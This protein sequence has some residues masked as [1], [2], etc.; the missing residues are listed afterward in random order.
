MPNWGVA[1]VNFGLKDAK[2]APWLGDGT[3]GINYDV[4]S[5]QLMGITAQMVNGELL[6]DD[7][8]TD[9]HAKII[10]GRCRGRWGGLSL[11]VILAI[12]N[13]V[14][15]STGSTPNRVRRMKLA[16]ESMKYFGM[17]GKSASTNA[18][19]DIHAWI[20]KM[21]IVSDITLIE[22]QN[23]QYTIPEFE[24][25]ML[26]DDLYIA[27]A[28]TNELQ[29]LTITGTPTGGTFLLTFMGAT[30][31]TI[32]YNAAAAAVQTALV[33]LATIGTGNVVCGGGPLPGT[34]VTITFQG[35]LASQPL[36]LITANGAGLTGG[37][38][39]TASVARTTQGVEAKATV[40]ELIEHETAV[41]VTIPP[42]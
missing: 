5:A 40:T 2:V 26:P 10:A 30:T 38:S 16:A 3:Y 22:M 37:S 29:T 21:K 31:A 14:L 27:V 41:P 12:S 8:K 28:G 36:P 24:A 13:Q 25:E 19:G 6:G 33:A 9:V 4:P 7:V 34:P 35:T 15:G 11:D 1:G 23:G 20:P 39:P 32:A 18:L 42:V 17:C